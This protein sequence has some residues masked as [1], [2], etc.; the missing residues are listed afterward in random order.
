MKG[1]ARKGAGR[2]VLPDNER[3]VAINLKLPPNLIAWMDAQE[4]SRATLIETAM[5]EQNNLCRKCFRPL[6]RFHNCVLNPV[7]NPDLK[8]G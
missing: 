1:G 7:A 4:E 5:A 3:K 2:P 8:S 6:H